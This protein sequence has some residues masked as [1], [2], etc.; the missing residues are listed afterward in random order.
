MS[1]HQGPQQTVAKSV[2]AAAE[3]EIQ[4]HGGKWGHGGQRGGLTVEG[5]KWG[6]VEGWREMGL[7]L[8]ELL[9][10]TPLCTPS[11]AE[12][13]AFCLSVQMIL[14]LS[15]QILRSV[16]FQTGLIRSRKAG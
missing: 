6:G 7:W 9:L 11:F 10:P 12:S 2:T 15:C 14:I 8:P 1:S 4:S 3:F 13:P 5:E 16:K